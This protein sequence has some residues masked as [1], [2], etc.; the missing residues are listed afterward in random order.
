MGLIL[1]LMALGIF[2]AFRIFGFADLASDSILTLGAAV[3]AVLLIRGVSPGMATLA[4][5]WA[6][7]LA[8]AVTGVLHTRR[9]L[10]NLLSG[11]LVMTGL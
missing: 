2:V 6:G 9:H 8:G 1:A 11:I 7:V 5:A 3:T 10:N 4:G